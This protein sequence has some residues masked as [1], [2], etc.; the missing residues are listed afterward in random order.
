MTI[1][2]AQK[3]TL[4]VAGVYL[5]VSYFSHGQLYVAFSH[6]SQPTNLFV[7]VPN[8]FTLNVDYKEAF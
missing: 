5:S 2:K 1:N 8:Q 6:V 4:R 7:Y 3:Q